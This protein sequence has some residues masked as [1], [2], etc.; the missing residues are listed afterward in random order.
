MSSPSCSDRFNVKLGHASC[1]HLS[2]ISRSCWSYGS[3]WLCRLPDVYIVQLAAYLLEEICLTPK[4]W[5]NVLNDVIV[6]N[7]LTGNL[8]SIFV[9]VVLR[10]SVIGGRTYNSTPGDYRADF[11]GTPP[12]FWSLYPHWWYPPF[13]LVGQYLVIRYD[14]T[15]NYQPRELPCVDLVQGNF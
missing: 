3:N 2:S 4:H 10:F 11:P 5:S 12:A 7:V 1:V 6:N 8:R 13:V 15:P 14:L 9:P